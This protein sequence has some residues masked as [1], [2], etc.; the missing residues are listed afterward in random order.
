MKD[1][2]FCKFIKGEIAKEFV[3]QDKDVVAFHSIH[4]E[5]PIHILIVPKKHIDKL[6]DI[7]DNDKE[8]LGQVLLAAKKIARQEKIEQGFKVVIN[9]GKRGG[10]EIFHLHVHLLGGWE[11]GV[12]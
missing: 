11:G 1:C 12:D 7:S 9:C 6:Q 4:P 10:Q 2:L 8:L 3:Y 5:A